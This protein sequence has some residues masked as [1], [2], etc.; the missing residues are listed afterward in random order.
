[1]STER[2]YPQKNMPYGHAVSPEAGSAGREGLGNPD[3]VLYVYDRVSTKNAMYQRMA[4]TAMP[5]SGADLSGVYK[6]KAHMHSEINRNL[7]QFYS[8]SKGGSGRAVH[9]GRIEDASARMPRKRM[10]GP[11]DTQDFTP[12]GNGGRTGRTE[13]LKH[14]SRMQNPVQDGRE[15][16]GN[17]GDDGQTRL[18]TT[19]HMDPGSDGTAVKNRR[20]LTLEGIVNFF[21]SMEERWQ[22]D[23]DVAKK[24]ALLHKKLLEHRR[25]LMLAIVILLIFGIC[26]TAIYELLFVV[27]NVEVTGASQ[28]SDM[29]VIRVCGVEEGMNLYDFKASDVTDR[30]TFHCP[31]IKSADIDRKLPSTVALTVE[32]DEVRYCANIFGE[33]VALSAG[34]RVLDTLTVEEAAGCILLRLPGITEAVAGRTVQFANA[35]HERYIRQVLEE[36][37][38]SEMNGRISYI[39]LRD[40]HD[41]ILYCDGMYEL[42]LGNTADL[43]VKL[44]MADTAIA[45]PD[46][47]QNTPARVDLSVVSEASVRADIRLELNE[48]P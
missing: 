24:Q 2:I 42:Q 37:A 36:I 47:P 41:L 8:A 46:F 11:E 6:L 25:G 29:A 22:R 1:M 38:A 21:E 43:K 13:H 14:A 30:I 32:E 10:P 26:C 48:T 40:E 33:I 44:R 39:D 28:Y 4:N 18:F 5:D 7:K 19:P 12:V 35:R 15:T 9:M 3:R 31:Y 45:D 27:R 20:K 16:F 23:V 17:R 34:L